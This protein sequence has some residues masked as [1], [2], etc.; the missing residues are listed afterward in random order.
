MAW[1]PSSL[2][3]R[4]LPMSFRTAAVVLL[5]VA[6]RVLLPAMPKWPLRDAPPPEPARNRRD[7]DPPA[8]VPIR[9]CKRSAAGAGSEQ[10]GGVGLATETRGEHALRHPG[11]SGLRAC[12]RCRWYVMEP[13]WSLAFGKF[14]APASPEARC[15]IAERPVRWGGSWGLGCTLCSE[16]L[17]RNADG[18]ADR[19]RGTAEQRRLGAKWARFEVRPAGLQA[20]SFRNHRDSDVH[21]VALRAWQHPDEPVQFK[22]QASLSDD[23]LLSGSVPQVADWLRAWRAARTPQS[24]QAAAAKEQTEHFIRAVRSQ[25]IGTRPLEMMAL[26]MREVLR[27]EKRA[28]IRESTSISLSFDDRAG[29]KLIRFRCDAAKSSLHSRTSV[30]GM[31]GC[32]QSLRGSSLA[33]FADDYAERTVREIE[34]VIQVFCTP[35]GGSVD[36]DLLAKFF[37]SVRSIV[38]DGA[39]QKVAQYLQKAKMPNIVMICR[40]P[41][42]MLRIAAKEPLV[43]SDRFGK[44]H[45]RLFGKNGLLKSV[46]FSDNLQARLEDCQRVVLRHAGKQGGDL[47]HIMRHFSFANH[48]FES[49]NEPRRKY[50]CCLQAVVLLLADI[51]GD[52]RRAKSERERA[53]E[54][55]D[56]MTAQDL[57]ETGLAGDFA[58]LAMET[59]REFDRSDRDPATSTTVLADFQDKA[60]RLFVDGYIL[61]EPDDP[62]LQTLTQIVLDQCSGCAEVRY[63]DRAKVIWTKTTKAECQ[64]TLKEIGTIVEDMLGRINADFSPTDLYMQME[65]MDLRA[66]ASATSPGTGSVPASSRDKEPAKA[67]ALTR[68]ARALHDALRLRWDAVRWASVVQAAVHEHRRDPSV[69]NRRVWAR[70]VLLPDTHAAKRAAEELELLIRFY[71][72]ISDGTGDVERI[73][74]R[75]A[76]FLAC[77]GPGALSEA[78]AEL[79]TEG[80]ASEE[81]VGTHGEQRHLLLTDFSRR[82][83]AMWLALRGRRF[84]CY[85]QRVDKGK[86]SKL[87]FHGSLKAVKATTRAAMDNLVAQSR[88]TAVAGLAD[89]RRTIAGHRRCDLLAGAAASAAN[90]SKPLL[91]FRKATEDTKR[92]KAKAGCW[93]GFDAQ[94][95]AA[96]RKDGERLPHMVGAPRTQSVPAST[97]PRRRTDPRDTSQGQQCTPGASSP[98]DARTPPKT[99]K[100]AV[101]VVDDDLPKTKLT[102]EV[103][104][105]W[106]PAIADGK[107]VEVRKSKAKIKFRP[108]VHAPVMITISGDFE[109]K[110]RGLTKSLRSICSRPSSKW[111]EVRLG[112]QPVSDLHTLRSFL[113]SVQRRP[114]VC[115]VGSSLA[116]PLA[117]QG[118]VSR[119]GRPVAA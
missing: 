71:V 78:C 56:A 4:V 99:S 14:S 18:S 58:E 70:L 6:G 67:L 90:A 72:S 38:A 94:L 74:G 57:L 20:D 28:A 59:L 118:R 65:A 85:K 105:A 100:A 91:N 11:P 110:H 15:W 31:V 106:L 24:W 101:V 21:K 107:A 5:G 61:M 62:R 33:D 83:A 39:L 51:A 25:P 8:D 40:D 92:T 98:L 47:K 10:S 109:S 26:I 7:S 27:E 111:R 86:R 115:G 68:K 46:Q 96:R 23:R 54:S 88:K 82:C 64:Q 9:G 112:G 3:C 102:P 37:G 93:R 17:T 2:H 35:L 80:P 34:K 16:A 55:L 29:F 104:S 13:K 84:G 53:Q 108:A 49:V 48:R 117:M 95:P 30:S 45:E 119:Y 89:R 97:P 76:S 66:W 12:V 32:I 73:L 87:R 79:V 36:E 60:R 1:G 69:D 116:E 75:H 19:S 81:A 42:H 63:G 113:L 44:Q 41:A 77:H 52:T 103:L 114:L 22:L 50:A 43:R